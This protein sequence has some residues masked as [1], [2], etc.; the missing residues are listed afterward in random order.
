MFRE[1]SESEYL[2]IR[3]KRYNI[4]AYKACPT[5]FITVKNILIDIAN[6]LLFNF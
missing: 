1:I 3:Q 4:G 5:I 2:Y 6:Y